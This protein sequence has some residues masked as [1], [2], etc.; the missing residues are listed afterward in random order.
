MSVMRFWQNS[1]VLWHIWKIV[2]SKKN[3]KIKRF[4]TA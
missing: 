1:L 4:E 3:K 2:F